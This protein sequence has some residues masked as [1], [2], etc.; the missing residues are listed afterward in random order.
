MRTFRLLILLLLVTFLWNGVR[1]SSVLSRLRT[2][3]E[4]LVSQARSIGL[5]ENEN[6]EE[7]S[8][9]RVTD[10][11]SASKIPADRLKDEIVAA[12]HRLKALEGSDDSENRLKVEAEVREWIGRLIDLSPKELKRVVKDLLEDAGLA[13]NDR[14]TL[15]TTVL[16][17]A[18]TRLSETSA[19]LFIA[20]REEVGN[21]PRIFES[22]GKSDPVSAFAW[23]ERHRE[24]MGDQYR[25]SL[26]WLVA[27]SAGRDPALAL[28]GLSKLNGPPRKEAANRLSITLD[29]DERAALLAELHKSSVGQDDTREIL[30]GLGNGAA[31]K[32]SSKPDSWMN[33]LSHSEAISVAEGISQSEKALDHPDS[34]LDW[35]GK[36]LPP[37][38]LGETAKPLLS[39]WISE[40]YEAAGEWINRQPPGDFRNE[41]AANYA[42][43]MAKRFPDTAKDWANTLPE[44]ADKRKLLEEIK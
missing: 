18:S 22:W 3:H 5:P 27:S 8:S 35:M 41:A 21:A 16:S 32:W 11:P 43:M 31:S 14:R 19:E 4:V 20:H 12:Y 2:E 33:D 40:D 28:A 13:E 30:K 38:K 37:E 17:L 7:R 15:L 1:E 36:S 10:R 6:Y 34:W 9:S 42:R 23:L 26:G 25:N 39:K 24:E 29:D 44:G